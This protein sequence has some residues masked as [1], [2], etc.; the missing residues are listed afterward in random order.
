M[1]TKILFD[2]EGFKL[3]K[4]E[5]NSYNAKYIV[6]NQNIILPNIIDF[7]LI[8][9]IY[10]LNTDIYEKVDIKII[11]ENEAICVFL[12]KHFFED[13]GLPQKYSHILIKKMVE[14][15]RITFTSQTI[16][17]ADKPEYIPKDATL[18]KMQ[19]MICKCDIVTQHKI[20][21]NI[22]IGF[23]NNLEFPP[24]VE[25]IIGAIIFKIFIRVKQFIENVKI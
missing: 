18:V 3:I 4:T 1:N 10:D 7:N 9:L 24:Y 19:S 13:V 5:E 6:E 20:E 12:I 8:K 23:V 14:K 15:D 21:F 2:K 22:S 11:N 25:K 17:T 16:V